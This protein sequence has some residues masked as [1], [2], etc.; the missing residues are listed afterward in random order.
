MALRTTILSCGVLVAAMAVTGRSPG[1]LNGPTEMESP[2][3]PRSGQP[4]LSVAAD[5]GM[6]LSWL[7]RGGG[8]TV[9]FRFTTRQRGAWTTPV[10]IFE[11]DSFFVNWA[12]VPS[13]VALPD[14]T[15]AAHWLNVSGPG[16]YS[17][18]VMT[19]VSRD[20]G[21]TWS[22]PI[23]PHRDRTETEHGFVSMFE[24]PAGG[25]GMIWLDG[26]DAAGHAAHG[27]EMKAEMA[28][29][30][31]AFTGHQPG[32]EMVVDARVCDCCPTA[33]VR[34]GAAVVVAYRDRSKEEV[35][36]IHVSRY[37]NGKWSTPRAVH[38]DNWQIPGCPVNGPALSADGQRVALAWFTAPENDARVS[39]AFSTD[40]GATFDKPIR[41]DDGVPLG[42]VDAEL[43]PNGRA[44]VSW[45]DFNG[46]NSELRVRDQ[47]RRHADAKIGTR[48][49]DPSDTASAARVCRA[50]LA[51]RLDPAT[52]CTFARRRSGSRSSPPQGRT[53]P[54]RTARHLPR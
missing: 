18:D 24:W 17:Y 43:L 26:R 6:L 15:I 9:R 48:I 16:K 11:G 49:T 4:H 42:R 32:P 36:D 23:K 5:G 10:T 35:R 54:P 47:N 40:A 45:I 28:L 21:R 7:E 8:A 14:G 22:S 38:A 46:G 52:R 29:R 44:L 20:G 41:V 51:D 37:A 33:A 31:A 2:A 34:A 13:V 12:D 39:V 50:R 1:S 53:A 3:P 19:R 30:A 27:S 25:L